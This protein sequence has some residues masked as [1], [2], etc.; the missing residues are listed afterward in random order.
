MS[1]EYM[2]KTLYDVTAPA[3]THTVSKP[4]TYTA[5]RKFVTVTIYAHNKN[6][7]QTLSP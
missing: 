7:I 5:M 6:N 3:E 1:Y 2:L 4:C